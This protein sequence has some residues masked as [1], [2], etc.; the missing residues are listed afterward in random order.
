LNIYFAGAYARREELYEHSLELGMIG[1]TVTSRWLLG[2]H[3]AQEGDWTKWNQ[4]AQE[5]LADLRAARWICLF[6]EPE[7]ARFIDVPGTEVNRQKRGGRHTEF[8]YAMA[9]GTQLLI[10]GPRENV[11]HHDPAVLQRDTWSEMFTWIQNVWTPP[12][13]KRY[14]TAQV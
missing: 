14:G 6:T 1:H 8:G 5:D 4:F 10:V 12:Q 3:E 7:Y 9:R 2:L 13:E 11:F